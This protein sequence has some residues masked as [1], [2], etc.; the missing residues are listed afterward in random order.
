[1]R[2]TRSRLSRLA[3]RSD[4]KGYLKGELGYRDFLV[5]LME[6]YYRGL[7]RSVLEDVSSKVAS[8][9]MVVGGSHRRGIDV[10]VYP[11]MSFWGKWGSPTNVTQTGSSVFSASV[12]TGLFDREFRTIQS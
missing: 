4:I 3:I 12:F 10:M 1:M 2:H 5:R 9:V 8:S 11:S 6:T 7:I